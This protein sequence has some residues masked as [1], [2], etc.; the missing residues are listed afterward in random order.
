M[1][2]AVRT[3]GDPMKLVSLV[4]QQVHALDPDLPVDR[5]KPMTAVINDSI[6][7][8]RIIT[9]LVGAFAVFALVLATIGMYGL[10]AYSVSQRQHEMGIRIALGA[11]RRNVL[12]L[13][14]ARGVLLAAIGIAIGIPIALAAGRLTAAFLFGVTPHDRTVFAGIPLL[15]LAV[16]LAASYLPARRA[17]K[18]DP[19]VALRTE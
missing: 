17:T 16:S 15:L 5:L 18:I 12:R 8:V 2:L 10:I 3:G 14:L 4:R 9:T 7:D 19:L 6:A 1:S 11:S 13:V